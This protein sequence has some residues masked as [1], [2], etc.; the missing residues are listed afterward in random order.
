MEEAESEG[1]G[2]G[3]CGGAFEERPPPS[4]SSSSIVRFI[5]RSPHLAIESACYLSFQRV[6]G[7]A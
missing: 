4:S 6:K 5:L 2:E 7:V 1:E 3:D